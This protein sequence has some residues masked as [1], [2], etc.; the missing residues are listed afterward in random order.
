MPIPLALGGDA[1]TINI[2]AF[3]APAPLRQAMLK[4]LPN[5]GAEAGEA[6]VVPT[7]TA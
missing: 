2:H 7:Y 5:P 6:G 4:T 1:L 3:D